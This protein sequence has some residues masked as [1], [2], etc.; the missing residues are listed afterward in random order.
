MNRVESEATL[1]RLSHYA[2]CLRMAIANGIDI[3][4][5]TSLAEPCGI[6]SASVRKD[7]ASYG[8]FG[9]QGSGYN[10]EELLGVIE[11]ILGITNPPAVV[12]IGVG[13]LGRAVLAGGIHGTRYKF[14]SAFDTDR[15]R[16]GAVIGGLT[17]HYINEIR[18]V[19]NGKKDYIGM[20]AVSPGA[21]QQAVDLLVEN[22]CRAI[23]S[24]NIEPL[25]APTGVDI[26][27]T[28]MPFEMDLL[29]HGLKMG[30]SSYEYN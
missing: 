16:A 21:A 27:Y 19:L 28:D 29:S 18:T 15:R 23:L 17:V 3:I 8:E 30:E 1:R 12:L 5:S 14:H 2:R 20:I 6:S 9:K 10:P 26:R 22:S 25:Y 11:R 4:T 13:R 7:L 24:F